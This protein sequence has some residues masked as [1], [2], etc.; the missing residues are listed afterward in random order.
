MLCFRATFLNSFYCDDS[1]M[2]KGYIMFVSRKNALMWKNRLKWRNGSTVA[3]AII[4]R[5]NGMSDSAPEFV[6]PVD[7]QFCRSTRPTKA[8]VNVATNEGYRRIATNRDQ[9]KLLS[10]V[11]YRVRLIEAIVYNIK[12]GKVIVDVAESQH[13]EDAS[14]AE[15]GA[16]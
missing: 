9:R 14:Q 2:W 1:S 10:I 13:Q 11:Q 15:N 12:P 3:G 7:R 5:S 8:I 4:R 6:V 16:I